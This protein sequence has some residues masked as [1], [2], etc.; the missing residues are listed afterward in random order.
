M[1][2]RYISDSHGG[3]ASINEVTAS[4][5]NRQVGVDDKNDCNDETGGRDKNLNSGDNRYC[6]DE[7]I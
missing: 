4:S 3:R 7:W 5:G 1:I 2:Q 6:N